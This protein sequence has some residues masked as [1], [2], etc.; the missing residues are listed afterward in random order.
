MDDVE[1]D[2]QLR[3]GQPGARF[4]SGIEGRHR[5]L[6][7]HLSH[8]QNIWNTTNYKQRKLRVLLSLQRTICTTRRRAYHRRRGT[9][10]RSCRDRL[11]RTIIGVIRHETLISRP[12][13]LLNLHRGQGMDLLWRDSLTCPTEEEYIHMVNNSWSSSLCYSLSIF[14]LV[15]AETG[16]LFRIAI[17]LMMAKSS[18]Q[19]YVSGISFGQKLTRLQGL[20]A[21]CEFVQHLFPDPR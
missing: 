15:L 4:F 6:T 20:R 9:A 10:A 21:T 2:S 7:W 16:G 17:K 5:G 12:D 13:E 18:S 14:T 3:R 11:A 8:T 1:D 19:V